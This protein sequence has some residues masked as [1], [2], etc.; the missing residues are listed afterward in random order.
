MP[1]GCPRA[2]RSALSREPS[3]AKRRSRSGAQRS[4]SGLS[5]A[6]S[7]PRRRHCSHAPL[8]SLAPPALKPRGPRSRA[9]ASSR[10]PRRR[11]ELDR[12]AVRQVGQRP[13][14]PQSALLSTRTNH[15]ALRAPLSNTSASASRRTC[16]E[17]APAPMCAFSDAPRREGVAPGARARAAR[18]AAVR[19]LIAERAI[20]S[21]SRCRCTIRSTRSSSGPLS[22]RRYRASSLSPQRQRSPRPRSRRRTGWSLPAA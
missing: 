13:C 21:R 22:L 10:A 8:G 14:D 17:S 4:S 2:P 16:S 12:V 19:E 20:A 7:Q 3:S 6:S 18:C 5:R 1:G 15:P 11:R 9:R